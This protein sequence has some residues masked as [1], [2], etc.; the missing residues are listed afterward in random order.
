MMTR[1]KYIPIERMNNLVDGILIDT[2]YSLQWEGS[3]EAVPVEDIIESDYGLKWVWGDLDNS[4]DEE[5][6]VMAALYPQ[7]REIVLNSACQELFK[8][9]FGTMMFTLA[10]ELGHWVLHAEDVL[11]LQNQLFEGEAFYCRGNDIKSPIEYQAD[12]FAGCLLMPESIITS[13]MLG[14]WE[15]DGRIE[16]RQL[17]QIAD[18]F[19]V[20]ISA[21]V[22]RAKQL[23]LLYVD[24][25]KNIYRSKEEAM[26]QQVLF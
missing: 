22:T 25:D 20:S 26:G 3:I 2:G 8:E 15:M 5:E 21:L 7:S 17:Y 14:L 18:K 13:L 4:F 10:H 11:G 24:Y 23:K 9:K 16:W 6:R 1:N 19:Q 12:L